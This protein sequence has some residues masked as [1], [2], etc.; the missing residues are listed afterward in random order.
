MNIQEQKGFEGEEKA[1]I[2]GLKISWGKKPIEKVTKTTKDEDVTKNLKT[3]DEPF[4]QKDGGQGGAPKS[5]VV[6]KTTAEKG[7][8]GK[9]K[10]FQQ[11]NTNMNKTLKF[12]EL[13]KQIMKEGTSGVGIDP[14]APEN[15]IEGNGFDDDIGDMG[16]GDVNP[17]EANEEG[18]DYEEV[19]AVTALK[20]IR[21]QVGEI[22]TQLGGDLSD[23]DV[24][25]FEDDGLG[26]EGD[27]GL[28]DEGDDG[29]GGDMTG[30]V[31]A[32]Q[33]QPA[34][35]Q[36]Q[37]P[38]ESVKIGETKNA[39]KSKFNPKMSKVVPGKLSK[40]GSGG[41]PKIKK[42]DS[43][44]ELKVAKKS[45]FGPSM[46]QKVSGKVKGGNADMFSV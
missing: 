42:H 4:K 30:D 15:N 6:D 14:N 38:N 29:L 1:R 35:G 20:L 46:S 16:N 43:T 32:Q 17:D 34:N 10:T 41:F 23:D 12:D 45:S 27:D 39:P 33:G 9:G 11:E 25:D 19:D 13:Y 3:G 28:G 2:S 8:D 7:V 36:L 24:D 5:N 40:K 22:I 44:G 26:D 18:E 21:K 31:G 37:A